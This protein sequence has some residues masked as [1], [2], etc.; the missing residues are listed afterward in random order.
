MIS[1]LEE[2][3]SHWENGHRDKEGWRIYNG[4][5]DK[6]GWRIYK[7]HK[8]LLT[9]LRAKSEDETNYMFSSYFYKQTKNK[10]VL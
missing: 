1:A 6:E 9:V 4:H 5:R 10:C 8:G 3:Q 2:L 7:S